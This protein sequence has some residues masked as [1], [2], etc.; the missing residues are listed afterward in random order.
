M[1][2]SSG[3]AIVSAGVFRASDR[4][5]EFQVADASLLNSL[6]SLSVTDE[7]SGGSPK[8]TGHKVLIGTAKS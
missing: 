4:K 7:P 6:T 8:P 5:V 1:I 2:R 3:P